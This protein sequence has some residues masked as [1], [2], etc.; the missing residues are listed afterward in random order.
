MI[1]KI[2]IAASSLAAVFGIGAF[3]DV[4]TLKTS[5]SAMLFYGWKLIPL[6]SQWENIALGLILTVT[7][8]GAHFSVLRSYHA[9]TH[10]DLHALVLWRYVTWSTSIVETAGCLVFAIYGSLLYLPSAVAL[11]IAGVAEL[12]TILHEVERKTRF[13]PKPRHIIP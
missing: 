5:P 13:H 12:A 8:I 9:L 6:L 10:S 2:Q 3:F 11:L 7:A 4:L 1:R